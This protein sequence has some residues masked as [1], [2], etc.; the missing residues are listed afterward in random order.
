[1]RKIISFALM[2]ISLMSVSS[3][4]LSASLKDD[5]K[6]AKSFAKELKQ[7][8][9][10]VEGS[11][12]IENG[13]IKI[14]EKKELGFEELI[15]RSAGSEKQNLAKSKA[16]NNAINE[17]AETSG[18]SIVKARINTKADD[19][20]EE[21]VDNFI[22]GY[23]RMVVHEIDNIFPK[24]SLI[25]YK[26]VENKYYEYMIYYLIDSKVLDNV[27]KKA[28]EQALEQCGLASKYGNDI[29][30]FIKEGFE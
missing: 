19:I 16:R 17:Y 4:S 12:T 14:A 7:D 18:Q 10:K 22:S 27:Q 6:A 13:L 24:P 20:N 26:I 9:W 5:I 25:I 30:N 15:G 29:S 2:M 23:E 11:T 28:V 21:E 1:M 3:F 8:G